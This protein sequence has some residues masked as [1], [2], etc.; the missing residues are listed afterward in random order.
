MEIAHIPWEERTVER[1]EAAVLHGAEFSLKDIPFESRSSLICDVAVQMDCSQIIYVPMDLINHQMC[2][3]VATDTSEGTDLRWIPERFMTLQMCRLAVATKSSNLF[4]IPAHFVDKFMCIDAIRDDPFI[5]AQVP[6]GVM[7]RDMCEMAV[8]GCGSA[9]AC[10]PEIFLDLDLFRTALQSDPM[11]ILH[12]PERFMDRDAFLLA[13]SH[14]RSPGSMCTIWNR[15][16]PHLV[17]DLGLIEMAVRQ[18]N[19]ND[20]SVLEMVREDLRTK[21][22]CREAVSRWGGSLAHVPPRFVDVDMCFR[23][24]TSVYPFPWTIQNIPSRIL[25]SSMCNIA[26]RQCSMAILSVPL[27]LMTPK[28]CMDAVQHLGCPGCCDG[29]GHCHCGGW[30]ITATP[31]EYRVPSLYQAA[32]ETFEMSTGSG[33]VY[34]TML[35]I[36][37]SMC[38][39][40]TYRSAIDRCLNCYTLVPHHMRTREIMKQVMSADACFLLANTNPD[41]LTDGDLITAVSMDYR[42]LTF[43][44]EHRRTDEIC[45]ASIRGNGLSLRYVKESK[46]TL[47][48]CLAAIRSNRKA[49][50]HVPSAHL[51]SGS[52]YEELVVAHGMGLKYVPPLKVTEDLCRKAV[53]QD[54]RAI[55]HVPPRF[56]CEDLYRVAMRGGLPLNRVRNEVLS[57]AMCMEAVE[58]CGGFLRHVPMEWRSHQMCLVAVQSLSEAIVYVPLEIQEDL[59]MCVNLQRTCTWMQSSMRLVMGVVVSTVIGRT[60]NRIVPAL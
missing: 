5:I 56:E 6:P 22:L 21:A 36:P 60:A 39:P 48:M 51:L 10:I 23:A 57:Q 12:L 13:I 2:M 19:G 34:E 32:L 54:Y 17:D 27:S 30:A 18:G 11:T 42:A 33:L 25:T 46:R 9:I 58:I 45:M 7:D 50:V 59:R 3:E 47:A 43:V 35:A 28:I 29:D 44:P 41:S 15:V 14:P 8:A 26:V 37:S 20:G 24:I 16:P 38:T 53:M 1:C 4:H 49:I 40:M 31:M 55:W 52:L